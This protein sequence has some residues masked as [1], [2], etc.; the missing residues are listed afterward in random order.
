MMLGMGCGREDDP[1]AAT[2]LSL[3]IEFTETCAH[4]TLWSAGGN[5]GNG[6]QGGGSRG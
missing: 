4:V 3:Q 6:A 5:A 2:A 1:R